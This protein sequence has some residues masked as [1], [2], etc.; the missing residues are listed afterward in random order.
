MNTNK[1]KDL[2]IA[3]CCVMTILC[4]EIQG[5]QHLCPTG[6]I[7]P[8]AGRNPPNEWLMCDGQAVSR[9]EYQNLYDVI[10]RDYTPMN[11]CNESLFCVPDLRGRVIVGVDGGT[12]R[13]TSNNTLGAIGG[14][15]MHTLTINEM[16]NHDHKINLASGSNGIYSAMNAIGGKFCDK[17]VDFSGGDQPHN[18]MQPYQVLNYI[19]NHGGR[20][21]QQPAVY[22]INPQVSYNYNASN[23]VFVYQQ[24]PAGY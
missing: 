17:T 2:L 4:S 24:P 19:I 9:Y 23:P 1:L 22:Q 16:P 12:G 10:G 18:N 8:F 13:V 3:A 21:V 20:I 14:E 15:E 11:T 7:I 6:S 5:M